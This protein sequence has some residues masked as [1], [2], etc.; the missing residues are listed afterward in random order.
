MPQART[1][2]AGVGHRFWR[3]RSAGPEFCDR[4]GRLE[5]PPHV[6]VADYSFGAIPMMFQLQDDQYQRALFVASEARG[7]KPG[8]LRLYRAD[9]ELPKTMDV[10]QEY[11]NEAGSGVIA[12]EL[13]LVIAKQFNALPGETWVLEIEP[14]EASGPDGLTPQ[15]QALYPRVEAIVRAFVEGELP[16]ELV[17]E[18]ARFG[19]QRPF[20]PRKVEVH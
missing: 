15:V 6:T 5:W 12:I 3:D 4:L 2:I 7:R 20:S 17:E 8:T 10:F 13:L 16:A 14:V 9:P 18:H 1:L 11:M 19:L